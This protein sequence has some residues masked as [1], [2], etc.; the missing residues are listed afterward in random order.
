ML[1][2]IPIPGDS[3]SSPLSNYKSHMRHGYEMVRSHFRL[4]KTSV[5]SIFPNQFLNRRPKIKKELE[6]LKAENADLRGRIAKAATEG[7]NIA[8]PVPG[9]FVVELETPAGKKVKRTIKFKDGR[10][11]CAIKGTEV[12]SSALIDIA[13]GKEVDEEVGRDVAIHQ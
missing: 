13:N 5:S 3:G 4:K 8:V 2:K 9:K 11:R 1:K 10:V 7:A 6:A 12:S